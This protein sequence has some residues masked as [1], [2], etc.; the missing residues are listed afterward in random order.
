MPFFQGIYF[1]ATDNQT[2]PA[3]YD[4]E[5][6]N[7]VNYPRTPDNGDS[8]GVGWSA[9]GTTLSRSNRDTATEVILKGIASIPCTSFAEYTIDLPATGKYRIRVAAGDKS[10]GQKIRLQLFDGTTKIADHDGNVSSN[11]WRDATGVIRSTESGWVNNN[12]PLIHNFATTTFK[13]RLGDTTNGASNNSTI[14]AIF[15]ESVVIIDVGQAVESNETGTIKRIVPAL[16]DECVAVS[17]A[18]QQTFSPVTGLTPNTDYEVWFTHG[19]LSNLVFYP[20]TTLAEGI[21]LVTEVN[22]AQAIGKSKVKSLGQASEIN[23]AQ[24]IVESSGTDVA[25]NQVSESNTSQ[26]F[27]KAKLKTFGQSSETNT[28]QSISSGVTV[29]LDQ[30]LETDTA[31]ILGKSKV[32]AVAQITETDLAQI[33]GRSKVKALAQISETESAQIFGRSKAKA[34]AETNETNLAQS[35]TEPGSQ[36]VPLNQATETDAAQTLSKQKLKAIGQIFETNTSQ[37]INEVK[38]YPFAQT[39]EAN[40]AQSVIHTK[41]KS[42]G[43]A[44]ELNAANEFTTVGSILMGQALETNAAQSVNRHKTKGFNFASESDAAQVLTS[45]KNK[46]LNQVTASDVAQF[47]NL[48]KSIGFATESDTASALIKIKRISVGQSQDTHTA[49]AVNKS[50]VKGLGMAL[51]TDIAQFISSIWLYDA[52]AERVIQMKAEN[53]LLALQNTNNLLT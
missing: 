33:F 24:T 29:N 19:E 22:T 42:L 2:D 32:K 45:A 51:E 26:A 16:A 10:S 30:A 28:A 3:N 31:Q 11:N 6:A 25:L 40:T 38:T 23:T 7:T 48:K 34:I 18:G 35:I 49:G 50:K 53:R 12:A 47:L 37:I 46:A 8:T 14:A 43:Q 13:F 15:I 36:D 5:V 20:F 52:A 39:S 9:L 17:S 27:G 4:A 1:R 41:A 44:L 21:N